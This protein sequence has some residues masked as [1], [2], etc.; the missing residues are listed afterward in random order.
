M[1]QLK[2]LNFNQKY[3]NLLPSHLWLSSLKEEPAYNNWEEASYIENCL[4]YSNVLE[5]CGDKNAWCIQKGLWWQ[6][7]TSWSN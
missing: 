7:C 6:L 5:V 3:F 2:N 4:W 1:L